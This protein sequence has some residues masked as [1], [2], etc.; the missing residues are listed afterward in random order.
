MKYDEIIKLLDAGYSREEILA[1]KEEPND[2]TEKLSGSGADETEKP[3]DNSGMTDLVK[4]MRD[5]FAEMKKEFT[6]FNI[7]ASRQPDE[8][9]P[10]D[11][12]ANIINPARKENKER[13]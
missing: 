5:V 6:A 3:N 12:I 13:G 9:T 10:E 11:I 1:M 4:E 2:E 7:M 8:K